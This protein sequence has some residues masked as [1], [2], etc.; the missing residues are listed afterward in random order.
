M[1]DVGADADGAGAGQGRG[2][3][4]S[5]GARSKDQLTA[6]RKHVDAGRQPWLQA[7]LD[8]RDSKYGS[9]KYQ[10]KPYA[11]VDCPPGSRAGHGCVE[12]REDAIAAYT[13]AL[14]WSI[15]GKQEHADKAVQIMDAWSGKVKKHTAGNAGLQTAWAGSTWARAGEIVRHTGSHLAGGERRAVPGHAAHRLPP[16]SQQ[17]SPGLQRELGPRHDRRRDRYRRVPR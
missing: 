14:L 16:R 1:R 5:W 3:R 13:Q 9:Y 2:V 15:T 7:F 12:E 8:M 10:A 4:A 11:T 6:V 17:E